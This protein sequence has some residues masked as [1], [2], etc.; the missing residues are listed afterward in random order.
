[1]VTIPAF[2][3]LLEASS[4]IIT[5]KIINRHKVRF[6]SFMIY[7]F[8]A[9]VLVSIPALYFFWDVKP[10]AFEPGILALFFSM[11]I[12]SMFANYF[13]FYSLK[14]EDLSELMPIRL[15]TPLF[16]ILFAFILSFFFSNY[17]GERNYMVLIFALIASVTLVIAHIEKHHLHFNKY[18][19]TALIG[20]ILFAIDFVMTK[21]L[22]LYYSP[23]TLYF[24]RAL[25]IF[26]IAWGFLHPK[27]DPLATKTKI[28]IFTAAILAVIYRVILYQ[29]FQTIGIIFTTT[30]FILSPVLIYIFA[31]IFLKEKITLK[32]I[33]SSI[34]IVACVAAAVIL[35]KL[36]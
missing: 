32:Q 25:F 12:V 23:F 4:A 24:V 9:I 35:G 18:S 7:I 19:V 2:G 1:M 3:A 34:I 20:S 16:T 33:I 21:P 13:I 8:G 11:I 36:I 27:I 26:I 29:G 14:R 6:P 30:I 5:K 10:E 15:T 31:R 22:L 17:L 28:M